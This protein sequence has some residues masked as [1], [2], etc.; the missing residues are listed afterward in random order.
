MADNSKMTIP[1]I[2]SSYEWPQLGSDA[3]VADI[4][5]GKGHLVK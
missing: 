5:G 3:V 2:L 4:G 1:P